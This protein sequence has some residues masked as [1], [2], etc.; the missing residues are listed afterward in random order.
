MVS[1]FR[2]VSNKFNE[3]LKLHLCDGKSDYEFRKKTID[4]FNNKE[5]NSIIFTNIIEN[6]ALKN[7]DVLVALS[8][9]GKSE[10]EEY[11]RIGKLKSSNEDRIIIGY[12]YALVSENT[13]EEKIYIE[14]RNKM[15]KHGYDFDIIS[16][17]DL[18]RLSIEI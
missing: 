13:E 5:I 15:L 9:Y 14:R 16:L 18:R 7:I 12:Y 6:Q 11:L 4:M 3:I 17:E 8:Y 1:R 10:R 2:K